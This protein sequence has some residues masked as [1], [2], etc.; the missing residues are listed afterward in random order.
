MPLAAFAQWQDGRFVLEAR[1]GH[2][3]QAGIVSARI[4]GRP[5]TT[6]EAE[7]LGRTVATELQAQAGPD[8]LA[9]LVPTP[10]A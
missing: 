6:A 4:E 3:E 5:A 9:A 10:S 2:P 7:A 1:L 8:W